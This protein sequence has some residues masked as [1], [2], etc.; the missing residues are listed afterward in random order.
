MHSARLLW[1]YMGNCRLTSALDKGLALHS[2]LPL[3]S[4]HRLKRSPGLSWPSSLGLFR[5]LGPNGCPDARRY[6]DWIITTTIRYSAQQQKQ[7]H[8]PSSVKIHYKRQ[9]RW[10]SRG[11]RKKRE[12]ADSLHSSFCFNPLFPILSAFSEGG[13]QEEGVLVHRVG[14]VIWRLGKANRRGY[15]GAGEVCDH[16]DLRCSPGIRICSGA[17]WQELAGG[18]WSEDW[19]GDLGVNRSKPTT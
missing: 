4:T 18:M 5:Q 19:Q 1:F 17:G 15:L 2:I 14:R 16:L 6:L 3:D 7:Q 8:F 10:G 12:A 13:W 11:G 9:K